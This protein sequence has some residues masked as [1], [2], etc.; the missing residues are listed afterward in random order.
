[1]Y[2]LKNKEFEVIIKYEVMMIK[3]LDISIFYILVTY[4]RPI[5]EQTLTNA[6]IKTNIISIL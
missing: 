3:A 2:Y 4:Y 1:M 5:L 6:E